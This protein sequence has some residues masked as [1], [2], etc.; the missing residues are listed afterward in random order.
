MVHAGKT[1]GTAAGSPLIYGNGERLLQP[2]C[3][4]WPP[5]RRQ[6]HSD[7]G[8]SRAP[9]GEC[10]QDWPSVIIVC[11]R[12]KGDSLPG[13]T[14][15]Y[16]QTVN[17]DLLQIT[18]MSLNIYCV[19]RCRFYWPHLLTSSCS[20]GNRATVAQPLM[21]SVLERKFMLRRQGFIRDPPA[22]QS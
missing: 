8:C 6:G 10:A 18:L 4:R 21:P 2:V 1:A 19:P 9:I 16:S 17:E 15:P 13:G 5:S 12:L 22:D 20:Q 7:Y 3:V 14:Q 11:T